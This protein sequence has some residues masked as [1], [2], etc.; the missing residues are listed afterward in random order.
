MKKYLIEKPKQ[1]KINNQNKLR[2]VLYP[3]NSK[4]ITY[5]MNTGKNKQ[6]S[7]KKR[8][9]TNDKKIRNETTS[10]SS[11]NAQKNKNKNAKNTKAI[12]KS[13]NNNTFLELD[14]LNFSKIDLGLRKLNSS[15][16][17]D[18]FGSNIFKDE[19]NKIVSNRY[20]GIDSS[21]DTI[22]IETQN[23]N[24]IEESKENLLKTPSTLCN[25]Y[26][27]SE[28][29]SGTKKKNNEKEIEN[30]NNKNELRKNLDKLYENSKNDDIKYISV[31]TKAPNVVN[32]KVKDSIKITKNKSSTLN[33]KENEKK[34]KENNKNINNNNTNNNTNNSNQKEIN[35]KNKNNSK[36]KQIQKHSNLNNEIHYK[37][38]LMENYLNSKIQK[39]KGSCNM[40]SSKKNNF[41]YQMSSIPK[42]F[43]ARTLKYTNNS[44]SKSIH[45]QNNTTGMVNNQT[46]K[47]NY[48]S[49]NSKN[50]NSLINTNF[51]K[52]VTGI[53][54]NI[55]N[56]NLSNTGLNL[57]NKKT[58]NTTNGIY[59]NNVHSG[60]NYKKGKNS[61]QQKPIILC[62]DQMKYDSYFVTPKNNNKIIK[63]KVQT[64][65]KS[66]KFDSNSGGTGTAIGNVK[67]NLNNKNNYN[68]LVNTLT[69]GKNKSFNKNKI[70]NNTNYNNY[71]STNNKLSKNNHYIN[72]HNYEKAK[73]NL[74]NHNKSSS[75]LTKPKGLVYKNIDSNSNINN[76]LKILN[77]GGKENSQLL[78]NLL[79]KISNSKS[80]L[81]KYK[82][83]N[84]L[85]ISKTLTEQNILNRMQATPK[86]YKIPK[87]GNAYSTVSKKNIYINSN[88]KNGTE[89]LKNIKYNN[90][91]IKKTYQF[92][93][94]NNNYNDILSNL[95]KHKTQSD[96]KTNKYY[97]INNNNSNVNSN[98]AKSNNNNENRYLNNNDYGMDKHVKQKLLDRMNNATNN[99]QFIFRGN[100]SNN[101]NDN[102]KVL[103]EN[104]SEIMKSPEKKDFMNNNTI[105]SNESED[106][107]DKK[108]NNPKK[109]N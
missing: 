85:K 71:N 30:S 16:D 14:Y 76:I 79:K 9:N 65:N 42:E 101:K 90:S 106:E 66:T 58:N 52:T 86:Y 91:S 17:D 11:R 97:I 99:W 49:N 4:P 38:N 107:N 19:K 57:E 35:N 108:E 25:Y 61:G 8:I 82:S 24:Y 15:F 53:L 47:N 77:S 34:E 1:K 80:P 10:P 100:N 73:I 33:L 26:D 48:T 3:S 105:I 20:D 44:S 70:N 18:I 37:N 72:N 50:M 94:S 83:S 51:N 54:M 88:E 22:K 60:S 43:V 78:Q 96:F 74:K 27:I 31:N 6:K 39:R 5:E 40:S 67:N 41:Y 93:R 64:S 75:L 109:V 95:F 84:A 62:Y 45:I 69:K 46:L 12:N 102:K 32:W 98:N 7:N 103:I 89:N 59:Y 36:N 56:S 92:M 13:L 68:I 81:K 55:N 23:N 2:K 87:G 21:I 29:A 63:G 28:A 104:L